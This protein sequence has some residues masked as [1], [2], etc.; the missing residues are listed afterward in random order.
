MINT[1]KMVGFFFFGGSLN[2]TTTHVYDPPSD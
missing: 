1:P 2:F